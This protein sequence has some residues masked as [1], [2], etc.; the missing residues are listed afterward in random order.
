MDA[1]IMSA[2]IGGKKYSTKSADLI[3]AN[4]YWDG[5]NFERSG[6][7]TFLYRT[8]KGAFFFAHLTMWQGERDR[9]E[10]CSIEEAM[11]FW[12]SV[13]EDERYAFEDAFPGQTVEEA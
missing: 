1:P 3:A 9:I 4:N 11:D 7:N 13:P 10:P 5:H 8:S 6:R 2:V 12:E